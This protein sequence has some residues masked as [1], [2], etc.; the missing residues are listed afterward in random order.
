MQLFLIIRIEVI[1]MNWAF[2][3]VAVI[4]FVYFRISNKFYDDK[5]DKFSEAFPEK[6]ESFAF[7]AGSILLKAVIDFA[8]LFIVCSISSALGYPV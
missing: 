3:V 6:T 4:L 7:D 8:V 2:I 1:V 5:I